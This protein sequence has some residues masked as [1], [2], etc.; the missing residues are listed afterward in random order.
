[1]PDAAIAALR[2][3]IQHQLHLSMLYTDRKYHIGKPSRHRANKKKQGSVSAE[4]AVQVDYADLEN[5]H[6]QIFAFYAR[7]QAQPLDE[8]EAIRMEPLMRASRSIMNAT[9][10]FNDILEEINDIGNDEKTIMVS[11][12]QNFMTRLNA[13]KNRVERVM[14]RLE[15]QT[16]SVRDI[17]DFLN[18]CFSGVE[19]EDKQFIQAC[20]RAIAQNAIKET[21]VSRLLMVNRLFTQSC[22]MIVLSMQGIV[23]TPDSGQNPAGKSSEVVP[24][25]MQ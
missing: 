22:R 21:D 23:K 12:Y 17:Q 20:S 5:L 16:G 10:N 1:M 24:P 9:R 13:M 14:G 7:I 19:E 15:N 2:K 18:N 25:N 8:N 4:M 6:S 11:M 3:E